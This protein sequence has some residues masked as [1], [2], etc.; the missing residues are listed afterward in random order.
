MIN[1]F[2]KK[3]IRW[4]RNVDIIYLDLNGRITKINH[5]HNEIKNVALNMFRDSLKGTVTDLAIKRTAWGSSSTANNTG[6]IKLVAEFGRKAITSQTNGGT[7][8][9]VTLTYIAPNEAN[10]PKIEELAWFAGP[11]AT[12][13]PDSG[14]MVARVLYSHQKT[15]L[16]ALQ[17]ARTDAFVGV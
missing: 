11:L 16:E 4:Y 14:I 8:E 2:F 7:G 3:Y 9:L 1:L 10:T 5:I 6:Q 17:V 12:S 15:A 13:T